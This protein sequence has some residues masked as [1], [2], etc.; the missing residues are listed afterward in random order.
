M[1]V[2]CSNFYFLFQIFLRELISNASDALDKIRLL[3]LTDPNVLDAISDLVIRIKVVNT[4]FLDECYILSS[5]M[6]LTN[7]FKLTSYI[8]S[9]KTIICYTSPT[10]ALV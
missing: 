1:Q 4:I 10:P 9:T 2:A 7:M 3:S 5:Y 6:N 8:R